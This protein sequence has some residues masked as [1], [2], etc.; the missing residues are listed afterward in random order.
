MRFAAHA[1]NDPTLVNGF[2]NDP[3]FDTHAATAKKM[4]GLRGEPTKQQRKFAKIMNFAILY[5]AGINKIASS[6][7]SLL[8]VD[9]AYKAVKELGHS[10]K[11][12]EP[13]HR[14]LAILLQQRYFKEFKAV[15]G[16]ATRSTRQAENRGL[17]MNAFGRH[18]F[19]DEGKEYTAFNTEVQG[20]GADQAKRGIVNMYRE[21]QLGSS[22]CIALQMQIHDEAVYQSDGDP[23]IDKRVLELL[24]EMK[25]FRV[26]IIADVSGSLTTWQDKKELKVA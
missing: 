16:A 11:P 19:L 17:A 6:L 21:L 24:A 13:P 8:S 7:I 1:A 22:G 9:D 5:G 10:A 2:L 23:K 14:S 15:K 20:D 4:W 3:S 12:G 18:R 26:P 25:M